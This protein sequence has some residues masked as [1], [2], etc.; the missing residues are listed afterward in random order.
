MRCYDPADVLS[1]TITPHLPGLTDGAQTPSLCP[2]FRSVID[3]GSELVAGHFSG[4][5]KSELGAQHPRRAKRGAS[6]AWT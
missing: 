5:T 4:W 1:R 2:R 6:C 3:H